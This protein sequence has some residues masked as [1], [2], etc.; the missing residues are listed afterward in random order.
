MDLTVSVKDTWE[1]LA[2]TETTIVKLSSSAELTK[3]AVE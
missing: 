3:P 1:T 2:L